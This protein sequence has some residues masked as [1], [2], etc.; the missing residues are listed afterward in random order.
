MKTMVQPAI[1]QMQDRD[2]QDVS[3][4]FLPG[5]SQLYEDFVQRGW[6]TVPRSQ[7]ADDETYHAAP[8]Y[9]H[10]R[11]ELDCDDYVVSI[12]M[13]DL[14]RRPEVSSRTHAWTR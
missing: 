3:D 1:S 13:V 12:R 9:L 11:K 4:N 10:F 14:P 7:M 5:L 6:V 8:H 2:Y